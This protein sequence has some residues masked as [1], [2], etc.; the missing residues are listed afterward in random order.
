MPSKRKPKADVTPVLLMAGGIPVYCAHTAIVQTSKVNPHPR[1]P[2]RHPEQQISLLGKVIVGQGWRNAIVVSKLSNRVI[3]GHAILEAAKLMGL[4]HVP[5][6][7]QDYKDEASELADMVA[8]NRI[9]ELADMDMDALKGL[10]QDLDD[11]NFDMDLTGFDTVSIEELMQQYHP[12]ISGGKVTDEQITT[13][14]ENISASAE[15]NARQRKVICPNCGGT[16]E[17]QET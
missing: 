13:S 7:V 5:I 3:K 12:D 10:L 11:G 14:K 1:N 4:S 17:I 6:D 15:N 16:F 8:D 2:N 9:A